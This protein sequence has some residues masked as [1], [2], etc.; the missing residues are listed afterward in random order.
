M[1]DISDLSKCL[2]EE[3]IHHKDKRASFVLQKLAF[4]ASLFGVGFLNT[5]G[6]TLYGLFYIIPYVAIAYDA[7]IA[8]EDYKVKRVG[9]FLKI[10]PNCANDGE[11]T[12]EIFVEEN[13]ERWAAYTSLFLTY[14][15]LA[16]SSVITYSHSPI[17]YIAYIT[18]GLIN[19]SLILTV[20]IHYYR[21]TNNLKNAKVN[22]P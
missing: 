14:L 4:V 3:I 6:F 18:W 10:A 13:R 19:Y 8:A 21:I 20:F 16:A 17:F 7:F 2:R 1:S 22:I 11:K 15:V 12:W 9:T 5:N